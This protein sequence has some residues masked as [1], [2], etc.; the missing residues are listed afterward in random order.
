MH[1]ISLLSGKFRKVSIG[2]KMNQIEVEASDADHYKIK[3]IS[4]EVKV[5]MVSFGFFR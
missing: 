3:L 1:N 5:E 4:G 2:N